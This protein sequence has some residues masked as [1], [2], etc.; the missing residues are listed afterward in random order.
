M[1]L[2]NS[3]S[4][5]MAPA[6]TQCAL[7]CGGLDSSQQSRRAAARRQ[8]GMCWCRTPCSRRAVT[9][10][11]LHRA[12]V[13]GGHPLQLSCRARRM[14]LTNVWRACRVL[15]RA[16]CVMHVHPSVHTCFLQ[17]HGGVQHP[18]VV[19]PHGRG[20]PSALSGGARRR[21]H[22]LCDDLQPEL[23]GMPLTVR[24]EVSRR[25][26]QEHACL[27]QAVLCSTII[28]VRAGHSLQSCLLRTPAIV[29]GC[30]MHETC[31]CGLQQVTAALYMTQCH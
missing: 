27:R 14:P 2:R 8:L 24:G 3:A 25:I 4:S 22:P 21:R 12:L 26:S 23:R 6:G 7:W 16:R 19:P 11:R 28:G 29:L 30:R 18:G 9:A 17:P 20:Q 13:A 15:L 1:S 31:C 10:M 5:R